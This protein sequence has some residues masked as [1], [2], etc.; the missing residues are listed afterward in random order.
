VF[1]IL[2][3]CGVLTIS[4]LNFRARNMQ[5]QHIEK[6]KI[7]SARLGV[8]VLVYNSSTQ[9]AVAGGLCI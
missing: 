8:G 4:V 5:T 2:G 9:E 7:G 6:I 3:L 1:G